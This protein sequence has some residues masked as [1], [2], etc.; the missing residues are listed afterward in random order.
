LHLVVVLPDICSALESTNGETHGNLYKNW[1]DAYLSDPALS[2]VDWYEM[3][4]GILHQGTTV[5]KKGK[6]GSFSYGQPTS[7][8]GTV[9]RITFHG[10]SGKE[11][12]QVDVGQLNREMLI[13]VRKWF[14]AIAGNTD[15]NKSQNVKDHLGSLAKVN[16]SSLS[17]FIKETHGLS[18]SHTST[19]IPW[20]R[21]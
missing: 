20:S 13:A 10:P 11:H 1:C 21:K 3:R 6:Y 4:K 16:P 2:G 15:P 19:S 12:I 9:H 18:V 14:E 8:G 7:S 5:A 17:P